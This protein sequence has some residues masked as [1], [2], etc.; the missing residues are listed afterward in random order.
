MWT[1][2]KLRDVAAERG[3]TPE[4]DTVI[5]PLLLAHERLRGRT[6]EH[7]DRKQAELDLNAALEKLSAPLPPSQGREYPGLKQLR[8]YVDG[9]SRSMA[10]TKAMQPVPQNV[11]DPAAR[12]PLDAAR[13][14]AAVMKPIEKPRE[15][16][17][18]RG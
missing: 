1:L 18:E 6:E 12:D 9:R 10:Q 17:R 13:A 7:F 16:D 5:A 14:L 15:R 8:V 3:E 2:E 11:P 4:A